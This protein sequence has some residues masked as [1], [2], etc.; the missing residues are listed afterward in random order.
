M[1]S[2]DDLIERVRE[3][4]GN[5]CGYCL[6]NQRYYMG[7]LELDHL[8]PAS[9]GG[10]PTEKNL[11]LACRVCNGHKSDKTTGID[12]QTGDVLP[13]FNPRKQR[14][15]DHF[16]W[17]EDGLRA[18]GITPTGRATVTALK[19]DSDEDAIECRKQWISVGWHPPKMY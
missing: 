12:P 16:Q 5:R 19:L 3:A 9:K 11:W 4:A 18:I 17:S 6:T 1:S 2:Y 15:T 10:L 14:W 7:K 13:L 8:I